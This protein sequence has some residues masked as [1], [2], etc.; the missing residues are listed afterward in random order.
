MPSPLHSPELAA[1]RL[2]ELRRESQQTDRLP[3]D[4][5]PATI[6][7]ALQV[8]RYVRALSG[9]P[10]GG[11]KCSLPGPGKVIAAA[12]YAPT[13]FSTV[14]CPLPGW[15][16]G[17]AR[18]EP[19]IGFL[20]GR[21]LPPKAAAYTDA[22]IRDA[23]AEV[24]L[25]LELVGCRY[26]NPGAVPFP[27]MLADHLSNAGAFLGPCVP[28]GPS[29]IPAELE[30]VVD[31]P[32]GE[33]LRRPG[34]HP[35]RNPAAPLFWLVNFLSGRGEG[36]EAGQVVITGS[37]AGVLELPLDTSMRIHYG[38]LGVLPV[39]FHETADAAKRP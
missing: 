32:E 6:D 17:P 21:S 35:D 16:G 31:G 4:L 26:T 38:D 25:A 2:V 5:R 30:I 18:V 27:E 1:R 9:E 13:V 28:A 36:I 33:I 11:W 3:E 20:M 22:E 19:E 39:A 14:P 8:Q 24:H 12:I 10:V 15:K 23:V 29:E 7:E 34:K 37:Y